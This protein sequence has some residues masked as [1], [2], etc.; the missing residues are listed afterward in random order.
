MIVSACALPCPTLSHTAEIEANAPYPQL[1]LPPGEGSCA[2]LH[3]IC[4]SVQ[5]SHPIA[6]ANILAVALFSA[7]C[8]FRRQIKHKKWEKNLLCGVETSNYLV[9][10]VAIKDFVICP[11]PTLKHQ[12]TKM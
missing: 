9:R 7:K 10:L 11:F 6:I 12:S 1:A 8:R 4:S 5:D 3:F 2:Y